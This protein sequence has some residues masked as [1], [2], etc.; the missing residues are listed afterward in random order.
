MAD[1]DAV[2]SYLELK[3]LNDVRYW[4]PNLRVTNRPAPLPPVLDFLPYPVARTARSG[5]TSGRPSVA[6]TDPS[7]KAGTASS[8]SGGANWRVTG[9]STYRRRRSTTGC[10]PPPG[11]DATGL[12]EGTSDRSALPRFHPAW[13]AVP[14]GGLAPVP[15]R[16]ARP[17]LPTGRAE[18]GSAQLAAPCRPAG[19][20]DRWRKP[21][22]SGVRLARERGLGAV[23]AYQPRRPVPKCTMRPRASTR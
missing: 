21:T 19:R 12:H 1:A 14:A 7:C 20:T 17:R 4:P 15:A 13:G 23:R 10:P 3:E 6:S 11:R 2:G 22:T 18:G 8:S 9:W 5:A 16:A